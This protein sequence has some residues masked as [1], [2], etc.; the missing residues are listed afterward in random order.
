[1]NNASKI[2]ICD[3]DEGI[4][5]VIQIILEENGYEVETIMNGKEIEKKV[6]AYQPNLI[7]LDIWMPGIDGK[8]V[9]RILKSDMKTKD[10]PIVLVS[11]LNEVSKIR[12]MTGADAFLPKPFDLQ[13]LLAIV[14]RH[15]AKN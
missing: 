14:K 2:L 13:D 6:K 8:E 11:A 15:I 4:V 10:I 7:F 5:E 3:D 12:E 9:T 1:M